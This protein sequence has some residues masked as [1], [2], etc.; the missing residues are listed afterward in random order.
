MVSR[1][2]G[3]ASGGLAGAATGAAVGSVIPGIG[4]AIGAGVGG[5]AGLIGGYLSGNKD[6]FRSILNKPQQQLQ[7]NI[8][9]Q[10]QGGGI[11]Q[12]YGLSQDYLN[13]L[14]SNDPNTYQQFAAP[15]INQF[16]QQ[17]IPRLTEQFAGLGGGLGGGVGNSSGFGQAIGGAGA[18]FQAQLAALYANLRQQA[19]QQA[20]GQYNQ[21]AG[22]GLHPTQA[23]QPGTYGFGPPALSGLLQG[24]GQG[25]G[26]N[27]GYGSFQNRGF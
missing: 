3:G 14:L 7:S 19:A 17:T 12:N 15:Y 4:T 24:V 10:L 20:M 1:I 18:Q 16:E 25:F 2:G 5:L 22:Y 8:L 6:K 23:Y 27:F 26:Q 11:G 21:L 9:A 13:K